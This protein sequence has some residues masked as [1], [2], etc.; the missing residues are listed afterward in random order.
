MYL[1]MYFLPEKAENYSFLRKGL[2]MLAFE[3]NFNTDLKVCHCMA[4]KSVHAR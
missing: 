4:S 2:R 3:I 1:I